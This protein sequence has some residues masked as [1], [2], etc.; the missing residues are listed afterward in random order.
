MKTNIITPQTF[1][2]SEAPGY[3]TGLIYTLAFLVAYILLAWYT[4]FDMNMEN[5]RRDKLAETNPEYSRVHDNSDVLNGLRDLTD[6]QNGHFRY[7][8]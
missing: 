7:S 1:L 8:G 5:K 6:I 2:A 3:R 4:W